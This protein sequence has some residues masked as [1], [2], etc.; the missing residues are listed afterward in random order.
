MSQIPKK[1]KLEFSKSL[2]HSNFIKVAEYIEKTG[3]NA[4]AIINEEYQETILL[5][6]LLPLSEYKGSDNQIKIIKYLLDKG[7]NVNFKNK[8]G[9]SPLSIS[10]AYHSLSNVSLL[11]LDADNI[12]VESIDKNGNNL[13]FIAI[14][15]YGLTWR[16]EQ[17][18]LR[19]LRFEIIKKLLVLDANIDKKN[20]FNVCG[21]DWI[22]R[23]NDEKL[24]ELVRAKDKK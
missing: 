5:K 17:F 15:E 16:P 24:N 19:K 14:R 20:N 1:S 2:I 11:L 4:N 13:I 10:I 21:R 18:E 23:C 7:A 9:Y 12:D 6:A 22:G 3:T 8:K